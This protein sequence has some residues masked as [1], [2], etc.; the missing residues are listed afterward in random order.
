LPEDTPAVGERDENLVV[1][2]EAWQ[3]LVRFDSRKAQVVE[4]RFFGG[5]SVE[6]TAKVLTVLQ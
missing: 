5:L 4:L 6:E 1:L 2:D 3:A